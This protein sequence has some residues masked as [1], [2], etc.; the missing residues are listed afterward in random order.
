[1]KRYWL[2]IAGGTFFSL[3]LLEAAAGVAILPPLLRILANWL[4]LLPGPTE[5][6][7]SVL[8][9]W[10]W[11]LAVLL[12]TWVLRRP[13]KRAFEVLAERL[14]RDDVNFW[15]L[16]IV[17]AK[18]DLKI[19]LNRQEASSESDSFTPDDAETI[20]RLYEFVGQAPENAGRLVDWVVDNVD[21]ELD[22][23]DF[24]SE[25]VFADERQRAYIELIGDK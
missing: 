6:F 8:A 3:L 4:S 12:L 15:G 25:P 19:P 14:G 11:P 21:R 16:S 22:P 9:A 17:A 1:M 13:L 20:E 10:G 18:G 24:L 7:A 23:V 5:H 2:A